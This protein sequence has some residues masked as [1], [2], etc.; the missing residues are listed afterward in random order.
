MG[1]AVG[2]GPVR[3]RGRGRGRGQF[4]TGARP[5]RQSRVVQLRPLFVGTLGTTSWPGGILRGAS[6]LEL[7]PRTRCGGEHRGRAAR[8]G[9]AVLTRPS[10]GWL[11]RVRG[12]ALADP[13]VPPLLEA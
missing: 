2:R 7:L 9:P 5:A 3:A 10:P 8:R 13:E 11:A 6:G 4:A 1:P 12:R